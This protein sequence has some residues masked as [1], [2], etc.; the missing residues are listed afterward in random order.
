MNK[1]LL[2]LIK[3]YATKEHTEISRSLLNKS[4][5]NLIS[6]LLDLL[7]T[8]YNDLNSST[9][10][11]TV[12]A[13]LAGY[14]PNTEKLGY[15]GF[16]QDT[17]T[18]KSHYCEVKPKNVRSGSGTKTKAKLNG[19]GNFTDYSWAKFHRHKRE[20]PDML[21]AGFVDGR[22]VHIFK[23]SFNESGFTDRLNQQLERHFPDGDV[24]GIYLRSASFVFKN[25][26]DS[27]SLKTTC[28]ASLQELTDYYKQKHITKEVVDHL[29]RFAK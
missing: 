9:M 1:D 2:Q 16:K 4:K 8:Y 27:P 26:K 22:I 23:F 6:I 14:Q 19:G 10:R 11:E 17:I 15:N 3:D 20:N 5:D 7:T 29:R 13:L 28:F 24:D 25:F 18:G 21:V 12:V